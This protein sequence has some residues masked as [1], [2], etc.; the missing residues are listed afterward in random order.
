MSDRDLDKVLAV[1]TSAAKA[2][3]EVIRGVRARGGVA[4]SFKGTRDLLTEADLAAE[5]V[6]I[7]HIRAA[8][9]DDDIMSEEASPG[10]VLH[11]GA[12]RALWIIDPVDGTTNFAQGH[13][14]VGVSIAFAIGGTVVVGVVYAPFVAEMFT[15]IKGRGAFLNGEQIET[16]RADELPRALI[17]TG[18]PYERDDLEPVIRRI[19]LVLAA[20]RDIR[21]FGA[22]SLDICCVACSRLDGFYETL[23]TWDMAAALLIAKEA[24]AQNGHL[25]RVAA[26]RNIPADMNGSEMLVAGP[27]VF[28]Q[29]RSLLF[30]DPAS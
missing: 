4:I 5:R 25:S 24:G 29:L 13:H 19:S 3:G 28:S 22:A 26:E 10:T 9:P 23:S 30:F 15:A 6:I 18:F 7:D 1:A 14:W 27:G 16:S 8:Y 11:G 20:C 21:R 2:A 17:G 12:S